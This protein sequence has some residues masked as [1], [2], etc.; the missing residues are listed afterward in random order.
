MAFPVDKSEPSALRVLIV[1]TV[2]E[3]PDRFTEPARGIPERRCNGPVLSEVR[4]SPRPSATQSD[5]IVGNWYI[6]RRP[7]ASA[8]SIAS[9]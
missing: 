7:Q 8:F 6:V 5:M 1:I 4:E 3:F 9:R 2:A